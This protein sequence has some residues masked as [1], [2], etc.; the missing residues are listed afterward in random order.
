[1]QDNFVKQTTLN[2]PPA[3]LEPCSTEVFEGRSSFSSFSHFNNEFSPKSDVSWEITMTNAGGSL[4][5]VTGNA[6][7]E[8]KT[9]CVR[10]LED[11]EI[12]VNGEVEGFVK[13]NDSAKLPE[14]VGEEECARLKNN[15]SVDITGMLES[16]I[17][18]EL[19]DNPLCDENCPGLFEFVDGHSEDL[20][21]KT[22]PFEVLKNYEF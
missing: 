9:K 10:C 5:L 1:M 14:E 22:S 8:F 6:Y 15:K 7:A 16:A 2:I 18:V 20:T 11:A 21:P 4:I 3:L 12:S 19:P 13:L 17:L